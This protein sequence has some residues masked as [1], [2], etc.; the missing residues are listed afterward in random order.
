MSLK[1]I[2]AH[3]SCTELG[4]SIAW[5]ERLFGRNPDARPM[6]GIV[7]WHHA[8]NAGFQLF[9]NP[10]DAGHVTLTLIVEASMPSTTGSPVLMNWSRARRARR[11]RQSHP[12]P[13]SRRE[14]GRPRRAPV[15]T[16]P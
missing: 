5:F 10:S 15:I 8:D 1:K 7:E 13:R 16:R 14:P 4:K 2:Y 11:Y 9:E 3:L 6:D 12:A